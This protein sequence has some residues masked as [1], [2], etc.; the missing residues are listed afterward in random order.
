MEKHGGTRQ[1]RWRMAVWSTA[2]FILLLPLVAMQFTKEVNW[3]PGDF[4]IIGA[5]LGIACGTYELAARIAVN[6]AYRLGVGVAVV[7]SF[8]LIWINL[9]VGIIGS[10]DNDLNLMYAAV[11]AVALGGALIGRFEPAAMARAFAAAAA[12]QL[13]VG[14]IALTA[15]YFTLVLEA[16]FAAMWLISAALFRKSAR[17]QSSAGEAPTA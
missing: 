12:A 11:L 7:A 5:M 16:F 9:A 10:E 14:V 3:G 6:S 17:E 8:L 13:M 1:G 4:T 2:A 15:G